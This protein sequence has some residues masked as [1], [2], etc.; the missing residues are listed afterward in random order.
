MIFRQAPKTLHTALCT[1]ELAFVLPVHPDARQA[2]V[3]IGITIHNQAHHLSRTLASALSQTIVEQ[4]KAVVVILD[5]QS[6]DDWQIQCGIPLPHPKVVVVKGICGSAARARNALL[7]FVDMNFPNAR[8]V[9][10]L[11]ADDTLA[12]TESV[13]VLCRAGDLNDSIYVLGSNHL[14]LNGKQLD[15]DNIAD[16]RILQNTQGIQAFIDDFCLQGAAQEL[17]SCNLVLRCRSGIRYPDLRSAEDHW[18]VANLLIFRKHLGSIA[19][20]PIYAAYSLG[21]AETTANRRSSHWLIQR[22]RLAEATRHWTTAIVHGKPM[23][24]VGQE[25]LVW[26]ENGEVWKHFYSWAMDVQEMQRLESL[27]NQRTAGFIPKP[28]WLCDEGGNIFCHY[29]NFDCFPVK[30][31]LPEPVVTL[32]LIQ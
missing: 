1:R 29:P 12:S 32:F 8:W 9:A 22:Q 7:D 16:P 17:P 19:P 23:L 30:E 6:T 15:R 10:R 26:L 13:S 27:L 4:G 21:G 3:I 24:G 28:D 5:D 11:D 20:Y 31:T 14:T 2:E 18:L 25:G